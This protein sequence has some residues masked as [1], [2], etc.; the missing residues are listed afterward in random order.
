MHPDEV[1]AQLPG[2]RH[3]FLLVEHVDTYLRGLPQVEI[4]GMYVYHKVGAFQVFDDGVGCLFR[5]RPVLVA[6]E[7]A[8]HVEVEVGDAPLYGVDAQRVEGG[9]DFHG[10]VQ[11]LQLF[12]QPAGH[13]VAHHLSLQFITMR[14]GHD[15]HPS[16]AVTMADDVLADQVTFVDRQFR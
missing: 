10:S 3:E 16:L 1:H 6:G 11:V 14:A 5:H 15:A 8:V 7:D 12:L 4:A 9:V 2:K 13:E